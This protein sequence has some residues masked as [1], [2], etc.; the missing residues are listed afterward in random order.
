VR[1]GLHLMLCL[2]LVGPF[3]RAESIPEL[4]TQQITVGLMRS[5][6]NRVNENDAKAAIN[7][8][9]GEI[10]RKLGYQITTRIEAFDSQADY[11]AALRAGQIQIVL[12]SFW[13]L[14]VMDQ[15]DKVDIAYTTMVGGRTDAAWLLLAREGTTASVAALQAK[16]VLVV[17]NSSEHLGIPWMGTLLREQNLG[18]PDHFFQ[19]FQ[20]VPKASAAILP[21]FFGKADA[22]IVDEVSLAVMSALNPQI[23]RRLVVVAR[24]EPLANAVVGLV[25]SHWPS[26]QLYDDVRRQFGLLEDEPAGRQLLLL[27]NYDRLVPYEPAQMENLRTLFRRFQRL[28]AGEQAS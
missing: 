28:K 15:V 13:D 4:Q 23:A 21:V 26:R 20:T 1:T 6:F 7:A 5:S 3:L 25:P 17:H 8:L 12:A 11:A 14:L 16:S 10:G 22:C 18:A 2:I 9:T 24:S 27:F 19:S